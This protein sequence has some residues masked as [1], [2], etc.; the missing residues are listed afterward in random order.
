VNYL[1]ITQLTAKWLI[2]KKAYLDAVGHELER[3]SAADYLAKTVLSVGALRAAASPD[4]RLLV[5]WNRDYLSNKGDESWGVIRLTGPYSLLSIYLP[6]VFER[7]LQIIQLR[8]EGLLLDSRWIHHPRGDGIHTCIAGRGDE[9]REYRVMYGDQNLATG[10]AVSRAVV[11]LGPER[12]TEGFLAAAR[13][14]YELLPQLARAAGSL[15]SSSTLRPVAAATFFAQLQERFLPISAEPQ[16]VAAPA[17]PVPSLAEERQ[18][19]ISFATEDWTYDRWLALD[20]PLT[21]TQ[22]RILESDIADRQPLRI[23]GA[24]GSGKTLLMMLLTLRILR[25]ALKTQQPL[26]V[27]YVVHNAAMEAKVWMR[28][29]T[30]GAAP[31]LEGRLNQILEVRTLFEYSRVVL[32]VGEAAVFD[33]DAQQSKAFQVHLIADCLRRILNQQSAAVANSKLLSEVAKNEELFQ[34]FVGLVSDEIGLAIKGHDLVNDRKTYVASERRLSRLH[35]ILSNDERNVVFDVFEAYR[36]EVFEAYEMFD[37]DD[38]AVSLMGRLATPLWTM[39]RRK[40]GYDYVFVDET[41]LFNENERRLFPLL[42]RGNTSHVPVV[43]ALDEAQQIRG[44]TSA[45]LGLLGFDQ[46]SDAALESVHRSTHS[47][48][49]L[50]F[51]VIQRTTDLF[52]PDFPDFTGTTQPVIPDSHPLAQLPRL[53]R[54]GQEGIG[55]EALRQIHLLRKDN[56]RQIGVVCHAERYWEE[57]SNALSKA[58]VPFIRLNQRGERLDTKAPLVALARPETIGGQEFDAVL[59][60]GLEQGVVP[61]R[62][63]SNQAL[64]MALEQQ[65]LREMYVSFTRARFRLVLVNSYRSAPT[66]IIA[67][68]IKAGYIETRSEAGKRRYGRRASVNRR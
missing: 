26:R 14:D 57:I 8:S 3:L 63:T 28:F 20:S 67:E 21:T 23:A 6:E 33:P 46:L 59:A 27:L 38:L 37:T 29:I 16:A 31:F 42:T 55:A 61:P 45:G 41:Q 19:E 62:V 35:G 52:G 10:G 64:S 7:Q 56:L 50:A 58:G 44:V 54:A 53:G 4:Q 13:R 30:L 11:C 5:V 34:V 17:L 48:L 65:A 12:E 51:F 47:I 49:R 1:A 18:T 25:R 22:R 40:L 15:V 68:A 39:Q 60:V 9:A 36:S 66:A 43:L 32:E 24:A 2:E